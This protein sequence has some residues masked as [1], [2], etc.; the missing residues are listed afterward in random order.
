MKKSLIA[1]LILVHALPAHSASLAEETQQPQFR[2]T[3]V[4]PDTSQSE[5]KRVNAFFGDK[6]IQ[7]VI[8]YADHSSKAIDYRT[9]DGTLK[10]MTTQSPDGKS[11]T[12][13]DYAENGKRKLQTTV[14]AEKRSEPVSKTVYRV[15]GIYV[16][17]TYN[18]LGSGDDE[19]FYY[20]AE[21]KP[22]LQV[23]HE[24]LDTIFTVY[25]KNGK[26][27]YKQRWTSGAVGPVLLLVEE[28]T[29]S[30][31]YRRVYFRGGVYKVE[32]LKADGSVERTE[33]GP[34]KTSLLQLSEPVDP[35]HIEPV[36][37]P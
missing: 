18:E 6:L 37:L 11:W 24:G 21:N 4:A 23:K 31:V 29:P 12:T 8:H 33:Q 25:D 35:K 14:S 22:L 16:V 27:D 32:D 15:D 2:T 19:D 17:T 28:I 36:V 13:T 34:T 7:E 1:L 26:Q 10:S 3:E 30:G 20:N 5:V 9:S